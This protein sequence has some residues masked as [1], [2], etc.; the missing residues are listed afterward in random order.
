MR[1]RFGVVEELLTNITRTSYRYR[2]SDQSVSSMI[3]TADH[4]E[5]LVT[6]CE[7]E[8]LLLREEYEQRLS[9]LVRAGPPS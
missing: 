8:L 4:I 3:A 2:K 6:Q 7:R 5:D 1:A 9:A